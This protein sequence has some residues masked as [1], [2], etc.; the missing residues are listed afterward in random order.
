[1]RHSTMKTPFGPLTIIT[2][3]HVLVGAAF[4]LNERRLL[5]RLQSSESKPGADASVRAA[6]QAYLDGEVHA[7]DKI[8]VSQ[9]GTELKQRMWK[10]L[11]AVPAGTT[12]SYGQIAERAGAPRAARA[13][14]TACSSNMVPLVVPCHRIV[15]SG[16]GLGGY[17]YGLD[18]KRA[19][20]AHERDSA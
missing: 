13:A 19:M 20:L 16:K 11:R 18:M 17:Y 9:P 8:E 2:R 1:M 4:E 12:A 5:E 14:G 3:D 10:E 15:A 7:I 6:I